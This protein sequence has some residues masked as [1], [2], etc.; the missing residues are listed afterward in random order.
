MP[1]GRSREAPARRNARARIRSAG[2][3]A[4]MS[5]ALLTLTTAGAFA[6]DASVHLVFEDPPHFASDAEERDYQHLTLLLT[7]GI[8]SRF[9]LR[10]DPSQANATLSFRIEAQMF[11]CLWKVHC[12]RSFP[13]QDLKLPCWTQPATLR[14]CHSAT[15]G[16][17]DEIE[18][19]AAHIDPAFT[20]PVE[21]PPSL[22]QDPGPEPPPAPASIVYV[23]CFQVTV[24]DRTLNARVTIE[25]E[26]LPLLLFRELRSDFQALGYIV[27]PE[28]CLGEGGSVGHPEEAEV[29]IVGYVEEAEGDQLAIEL[30]VLPGDA[31]G[32]DRIP[33]RHCEVFKEEYAK[34]KRAVLDHFRE[35]LTP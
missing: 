22:C 15:H 3:G 17:L 16:D 19:L 10:D 32:L 29:E 18:C 26:K 33:G 14:A 11:G 24:E 13:A 5:G 28:D 23:R 12:V 4:V 35:T 31:E 7:D 6:Q 34:L 25:T 1:Q 2:T 30:F 21:L 8:S 20:P 27:R 9:E